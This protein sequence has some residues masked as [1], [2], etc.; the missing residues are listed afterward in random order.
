MTEDNKFIVPEDW[1]PIG[2]AAVYATVTES[3]LVSLYNGNQLVPG[4]TYQ[5]TGEFEGSNMAQK[6]L[7]KAIAPNKLEETAWALFYNADFQHTGD[8]S[9]ITLD[10]YPVAWSGN[11]TVSWRA[12]QEASL[13]NGDVVI[14]SRNRY[15]AHYLVVDSGSINGTSPANN[16]TAYTFLGISATVGYVSEWNKVWY[17]T[18]VSIYGR[19]DLVRDNL[20]ISNPNVVAISN[21]PSAYYGKFHWGDDNVRNN[22]IN[23][24][25]V[26]T[27]DLHIGSFKFNKFNVG[28]L[29]TNNTGE[30]ISITYL[31]LDEGAEIT[32]NDFGTDGIA[33]ISY[34]KLAQYSK[35][36]NNVLSRGLYYINLGPE[37]YYQNKDIQVEVSYM[38]LDFSDE[39]PETITTSGYSYSNRRNVTLLPQ[40]K[41]GY[42]AV[43]S[44]IGTNAPVSGLVHSESVIDWITRSG[45]GVYVGT[46]P[47][48]YGAYGVRCSAGNIVGF[49]TVEPTSS[50]TITLR[51]FDP[52]GTPSD[53]ILNNTHL[54]IFITID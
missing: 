23:N 15:L 34:S 25:D 22:Y 19:H 16:T 26:N 35:F 7:I 17:S 45:V 4:A 30:N 6:M 37:A 38:N 44:Q 41:Y 33:T 10:N 3:E 43:V 20:F 8:Y 51:T 29:F 48:D 1:N 9:A 28:S 32:N 31:S 49:V 36:S 39:S 53:G 2:Q 13:V 54:Q 12:T 40:D 27:L 42:S 50:T 21:A 5:V 47:E 11:P 24:A 52:T 18:I 14:A 46:L